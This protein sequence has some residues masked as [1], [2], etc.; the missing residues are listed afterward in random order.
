MQGGGSD[1]AAGAL[2]RVGLVWVFQDELGRWRVYA[3]WEVRGCFKLVGVE[4]VGTFT[5]ERGWVLEFLEW[6]WGEGTECGSSEAA[7][8]SR[9]RVVG[10]FLLCYG[11]WALFE[12]TEKPLRNLRGVNWWD[13]C[14]GESGRMAQRESWTVVRR[15][16]EYPTWGR[17]WPLEAGRHGAPVKSWSPQEA[18]WRWRQGEAQVPGLAAWW[19]V[20]GARYCWDPPNGS[21]FVEM[22]M[23]SGLDI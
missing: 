3:Y 16:L 20:C 4:C 21:M 2:R 14:L 7:E 17:C 19:M 5:D 15:L 9:H 10:D 12:G 11:A 1:P 8:V 18:L 6:V 22:R 23:S 13:V